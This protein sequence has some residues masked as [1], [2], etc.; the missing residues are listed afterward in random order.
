MKMP[1]I[2]SSI[3]FSYATSL[4]VIGSVNYI[5]LKT[6][7]KLVDSRFPKKY[8]DTP[9]FSC[10]IESPQHKNTSNKKGNHYGLNYTIF[11]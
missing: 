8:S 4:V 5:I 11:I 3:F 9:L 1:V 7:L 6:L 10:I 2:K